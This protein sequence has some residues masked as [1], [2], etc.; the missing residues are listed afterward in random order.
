MWTVISLDGQ[1]QHLAQA[2][3]QAQPRGGLVEAGL[4][5]QPGIQLLIDLERGF[6]GYQA[7]ALIMAAA[8]GGW[9][10]AKNLMCRPGGLLYL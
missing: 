10:G 3:V 6:H 9:R 1:A 4:G 2:V 8:G 7:S 5:R